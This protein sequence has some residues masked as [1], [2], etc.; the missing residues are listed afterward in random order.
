MAE[1]RSATEVWQLLGAAPRSLVVADVGAAL[2]GE[3]PP[4]QPLMDAE[5][6]RLIAIDADQRHVERLRAHWGQA[7]EVIACAVGD[8]RY[9]TLHVCHEGS[10]MT[11]LLEPDPESLAFFNLFPKFGAVERTEQIATRRLDDL[12]NVPP[13]DFLKLDIQGSELMV[14]RNGWGKLAQCA[15]IQA[16]VSFVTLYKNQ[17]TFAAIDIELRQHGFIPHRFRQVKAWSIAPTMRNNDPRLPFHQLLEGD[18][19]YIR[20]LVHPGTMTVEQIR[21]LALLAH[22]MLG[23]PDLAARCILILQARGALP[24]GTVDQYYRLVPKDKP[25][26]TSP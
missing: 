16:E 2:F 9:H 4:Y 3:M 11:S 24:A 23:S 5:L 6:A 25:P 21:K 1:Q 12:W 13:I 18:V 20:D 8:G 22:Y 17:P 14:L 15:A 26:G 10:G 19:V 7:A